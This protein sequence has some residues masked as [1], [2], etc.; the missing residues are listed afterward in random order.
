MELQ[1]FIETMERLAPP[2]LAEP[3]DHTGL[4]LRPLSPRDVSTVLLTIDLTREVAEEAVAKE[5]QAVVSYHPVLFG[6]THRLDAR[7]PQLA[8]VMTLVKHEVA[9]YSPH[10]A[11][12]A[13]RGGTNDWLAGGI[14]KGAAEVL[15]PSAADPDH[16]MGRRIELESGTRPGDL[17]AR[18]RDFLGIDAVHIASPSANPLCRTAAICVGAGADVLLDA[19]ADVLIT[20]EMKHHDLLA[21]TGRGKAVL[22]CGHTE[23]ERGYLKVLARKLRR[24]FGP[25]VRVLRSRRDR[26]P[27]RWEGKGL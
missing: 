16:G 9:L 1:S 19:D 18:L 13:V 25:L 23:T 22:L 5:A 27:G 17:A 12:D 2:E 8:A 14:G 3:W 24:A 21:A 7:D 10:T 11:L 20:G 6:G 4:L 26:P 15:R